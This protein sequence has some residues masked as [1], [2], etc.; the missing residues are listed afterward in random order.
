MNR[1]ENDQLNNSQTREQ[2][3]KQSEATQTKLN[4]ADV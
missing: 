4:N 1:G 3:M 2:Y